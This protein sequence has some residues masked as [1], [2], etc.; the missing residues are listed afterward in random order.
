MCARSD[1]NGQDFYFWANTATGPDYWPVK[2]NSPGPF[3]A[4]SWSVESGYRPTANRPVD[5][6]R[7]SENSNAGTAQQLASLARIPLGPCCAQ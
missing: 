5:F 1:F 7:R 3:Q 4:G 2:S 6:G